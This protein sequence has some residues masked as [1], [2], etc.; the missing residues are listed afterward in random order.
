MG[1]EIIG[2]SVDSHF[3]HAAYAQR[4]RLR[5]PLLSDLNR[6][7]GP[8]LVGTY[9]SVSQGY[10]GLARRAVLVVAPDKIVSWVWAS[11]DPGATP[12]TEDVREAVQEVFH[13][14]T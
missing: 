12:D 3:T 8:K 11:D 13:R 10:E 2:V 4:L 7:V 5:F 1:A 14:W 9:P 6:S